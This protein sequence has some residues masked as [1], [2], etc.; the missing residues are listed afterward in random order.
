MR[1]D[2]RHED[3]YRHQGGSNCSVLAVS[4]RIENTT[5]AGRIIGE[6]DGEYEDAHQNAANDTK[7][8]PV[9]DE[10]GA[11]MIVFGK[12]CQERRGRNFINAYDDTR[13]AGHQQKISK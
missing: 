3:C 13:R 10:F 11:L 8:E 6:D 1:T 9:C 7:E 5:W 12:L 4:R 2:R